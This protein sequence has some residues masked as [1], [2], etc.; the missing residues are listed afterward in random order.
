M[1]NAKTVDNT[2]INKYNYKFTAYY[3]NKMNAVKQPWTKA[4]ISDVI[5][6]ILMYLTRNKNKTVINYEFKKDYHFRKL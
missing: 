6:E 2:L 5:S 3:E 4:T 1:E